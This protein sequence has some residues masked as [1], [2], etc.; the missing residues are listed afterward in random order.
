MESD[1]GWTLL[2]SGDS[3]PLHIFV[4]GELVFFEYEDGPPPDVCSQGW[5]YRLPRNILQ[6]HL[7]IHEFEIICSKLELIFWH[8]SSLRPFYFLR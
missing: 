8:S 4:V 2:E 3:K 1:G 5:P 7:G 6:L